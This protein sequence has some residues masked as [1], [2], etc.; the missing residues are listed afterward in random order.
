MIRTAAVSAVGIVATATAAA[1][2]HDGRT[3]LICAVVATGALVAI[4]SST[5]AAVRRRAR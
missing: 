2:V 5:V 1:F 4:A 3:A